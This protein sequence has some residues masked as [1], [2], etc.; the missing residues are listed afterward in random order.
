MASVISSKGPSV[1]G[2]LISEERQCVQ[3]GASRI[4]GDGKIAGNKYPRR[5]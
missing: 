1:V 4:W 3:P 5:S 2:E